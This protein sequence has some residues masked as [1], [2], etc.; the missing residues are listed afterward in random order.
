MGFWLG[1]RVL[2]DVL[3]YWSYVLSGAAILFALG[4]YIVASW[5]GSSGNDGS[6]DVCIFFWGQ[7]QYL[8][9]GV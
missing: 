2:E 8:L 5:G 4:F 9:A 3:L 7:E 1:C 6:R